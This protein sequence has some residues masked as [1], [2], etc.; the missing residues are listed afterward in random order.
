M[1][2]MDETGIH[3]RCDRCGYTWFYDA[4]GRGPYSATPPMLVSG[5]GASPFGGPVGSG[6][7]PTLGESCPRCGSARCEIVLPEVQ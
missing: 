2:E 7:A 5:A 4:E 6:I 3:W 1:D